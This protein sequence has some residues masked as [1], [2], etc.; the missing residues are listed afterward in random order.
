M[1]NVPLLTSVLLA[2]VISPALAAGLNLNWGTVCYTE[3]PVS[4]ITFACNTNTGSWHLVTSVMTDI[5]LPGM[6]GVE[7]TM[8]G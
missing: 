6:I 1:K 8:V 2:L 5:D 7:I 4:A 3:A